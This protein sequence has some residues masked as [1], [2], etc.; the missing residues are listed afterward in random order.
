MKK[1]KK[2]L[3]GLCLMIFVMVTGCYQSS[4]IASNE[5]IPFDSNLWEIET[6]E[7]RAEDY[8]GQKSL[9]LKGGFATV[10][11]SEF[12]DGIIEYDLAFDGQRGFVGNVWRLQ[13]FGNFEKFYMRPHQSGNPDASQYTPF[14]N[15]ISSVQLYSGIDDFLARLTYPFNEWIHV[16]VVVSGENAEIYV[17]DMEEPALI[18]NDLKR[19]IKP[20]KVGLFV[21]KD[22]APAHFANFSYTSTSN[23]PLKGE[24]NPPEKAPE[25]TVISWLVSNSFEEQYLED[26]YQLFTEK[27]KE[28]FNWKKLLADNSGIAN[29][30]RL[31]GIE[32]GKN[33]VFARTKI[34]TDRDTI[35]QLKFGFSDRVKVYLNG[36]LLYGGSDVAGSRDYRFLGTVGLFDELY[37]PL[38]KGDN[39]LWI[40]VSEGE[41]LLGWGL[42]A[43]FSD[44]EG[45]S[46]KD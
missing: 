5:I 1:T 37:L 36:R 18:I 24:I 43:Q 31:Q 20:G 12:T 32:D 38:K 41:F 46:L 29:F 44:P 11:D 13:D 4:S 40:S 15:E 16:K 19:D 34:I 23:P 35:K 42:I 2:Y 10:K 14:F 26:K 22:F 17:K 45:I 33:T 39:E 3:L 25:G 8:L 9:F 6:L 30:A 7:S 27:E 21:E 28:K